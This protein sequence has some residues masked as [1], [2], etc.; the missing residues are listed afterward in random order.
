MNLHPIGN[1]FMYIETSSI[2]HCNKVFGSFERTD[3][4]QISNILFHYNRVSFLMNDSLKSMDKIGIQ[5]LLA[6]NT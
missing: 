1:S 5:L 6:D 3:I 4:L 2:N